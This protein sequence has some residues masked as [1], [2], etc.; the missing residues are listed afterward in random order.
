MRV[1]E[2]LS[3]LYFLNFSMSFRLLDTQSFH[4][5]AVLL[6]SNSERFILAS[7]PLKLTFFK[8]LVEQEKTVA[9]PVERF[10]PVS[11]S[12]AKQEQRVGTRVKTK[13]L[14]NDSRQTVDSTTKIRV[15]AGEVDL[16]SA[17]IAQHDLSTRNNAASVASSAPLCTSAQM[18]PTF[19]ETA[20]LLLWLS[21]Q[22]NGT[23]TN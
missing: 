19:T 12:A 8:P 2:Q 11:S 6:S 3:E 13:L 23:S 15:A 9:L 18:L 17:E 5:P 22:D 7:R 20:M 21:L 10:D 16:R 4:Q 1:Y 14:F